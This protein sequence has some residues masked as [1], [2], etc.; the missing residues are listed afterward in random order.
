[1]AIL[2]IFLVLLALPTAAWFAIG[3]R[4]AHDVAQASAIV[5]ANPPPSPAAARRATSLLRS[6]AWLNPDL[7]VDVLRGQLALAQG[8][9]ARARA[10]LFHVIRREPKLLAAWELY[11]R[12]SVDNP[13][14]FYAAQIG[15]RRLVHLF[16]PR[17]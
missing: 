12:A 5:S 16:A 14:A 6:A 17:R 15:I 11:A 8:N 2:R 10:I 7:E 9:L 3:T 13:V 1:M 4:Q